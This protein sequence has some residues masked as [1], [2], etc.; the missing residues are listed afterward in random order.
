MQLGGQENAVEDL[1]DC[2]QESNSYPAYWD[3]AIIHYQLLNRQYRQA[4]LKAEAL[5][6]NPSAPAYFYLTLCL[7]LSGKNSEAEEYAAKLKRT[8]PLL[9]E[10]RFAFMEHQL[11]EESLLKK[12]RQLPVFMN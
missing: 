10:N 1:L 3:L 8:A 7:A 5:A 6:Q 9:W 2:I 12:I 11:P 4:L